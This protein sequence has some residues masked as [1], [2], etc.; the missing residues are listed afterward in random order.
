MPT[1]A[2]QRIFA[3]SHQSLKG[4]SQRQAA[5]G[6]VR[7]MA[8]VKAVAQPSESVPFASTSGHLE[9]WNSNSWKDFVALQQPQYPDKVGVLGCRPAARL[10]GRLDWAFFHHPMGG[11]EEAINIEFMLDP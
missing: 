10:G 5:K 7:R 9:K 4:G 1:M 11:E 8:V 2:V 6:G 3:K